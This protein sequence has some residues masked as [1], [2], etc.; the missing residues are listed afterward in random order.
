MR[1]S[2]KKKSFS[3]A[4][5][6]EVTSNMVG[7]STA[8]SKSN[9]K[10]LALS[11]EESDAE[12]SSSLK[13]I[14]IEPEGIYRHTRIRTGA[15]APIDYNNLAK[16]VK[17]NDEHSVIIESHLSNSYV[18]KETFTYMA[19]TPEEVA[20]KFEEQ[21]RVQQAQHE[22][23][24]AQQESINDLKKIA[25]LLKKSKK[26]TKSSKTKLLPAKARVKR[27]RMKTLPPNTL[28]AIITTLNMKILSLLLLKN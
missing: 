12:Y 17:S 14:L 20:S 2:H 3:D 9:G 25:L 10:Q 11:S 5:Y 1:Q 6:P 13:E 16:V 7:P 21:T 15:I 8:P 22:M 18:E 28:M 27:R 19:N 23:L 26:K 4:E 24:Q